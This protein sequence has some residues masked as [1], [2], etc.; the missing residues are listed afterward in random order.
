LP[1]FGTMPIEWR[2]GHALTRCQD[3]GKNPSEVEDA[4]RAGNATE[5]AS[6]RWEFYACIG[7]EMTS[8]I[9]VVSHG[10]IVPVTAYGRRVPCS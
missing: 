7:G 3:R 2:G 10:V 6:G 9:V 1:D 8:I 4:I 5:R